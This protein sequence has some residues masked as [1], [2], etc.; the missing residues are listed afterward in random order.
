MGSGRERGRRTDDPWRDAL[1]RH[2]AGEP[3]EPLPAAGGPAAPRRRRL[4]IAL[5]AAGAAL[6]LV[7]IGGGYLGYLALENHQR[8]D[9]WRDRSAALEVVVVDRT[10]A[11]NRQTVRL[12]RAAGR[13]RE[14]RIAISRSEADVEQLEARQ[15][16]LASEKA[17]LEDE[18][19]LL[20]AQRGDLVE[21]ANQ[22]I[23][24]SGG[25]A[26]LVDA[27][28]SGLEPDPAYGESV[29]DVC[30]S[31]GAAIDDYQDAYPGG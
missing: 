11:L 9:E 26:D 25:L 10:T 21:V 24:C 19:A 31:A 20:E 3:T 27:Y 14:A 22:L 1:G 29:I 4:L 6:V 8:A 15:R 23:G 2:I 18:R 7:L 5:L 28:A 13:L 30:R 17:R 12:N 16:E